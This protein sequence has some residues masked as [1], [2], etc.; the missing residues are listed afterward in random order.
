[1]DTSGVK[2]PL[3][4]RSTRERVSKRIGGTAKSITPPTLVDTNG[5]PAA[6]ASISAVGVPSF[7]EVSKPTSAAAHSFGM[8]LRQP[9]MCAFEQPAVRVSSF[10]RSVPSPTIRKRKLGHRSAS[11]IIWAKSS[12]FFI[13]T[14]R[15]AQSATKWESSKPNMRRNWRRSCPPASQSYDVRS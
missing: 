14:S 13:G 1:M 4:A 12:T 10:L 7:R 2:N 6:I 3:A 11:R 8:S 9:A 15:P 5:L